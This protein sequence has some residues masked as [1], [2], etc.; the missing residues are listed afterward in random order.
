MLSA[1]GIYTAFK[2]HSGM[3]LGSCRDG[4]LTM[5]HQMIT[6][7]ELTVMN[8][9]VSIPISDNVGGISNNLSKVRNGTPKRY[10]Q[11]GVRG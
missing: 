11:S 10:G 3:L 4:C 1:A 5:G 6:Q 9:I 7:S 8:W 2:N